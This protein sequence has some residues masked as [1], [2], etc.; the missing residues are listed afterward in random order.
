MWTGKQT[1][2]FLQVSERTLSNWRWRG[3]GPPFLKIGSAIRYDPQ[4]V[5]LWAASQE[6]TST[7]DAGRV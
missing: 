3:Y 7:A 2:K 6:R 1:A 4:V 5:R